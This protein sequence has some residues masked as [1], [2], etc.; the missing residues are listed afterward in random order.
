MKLVDL[1]LTKTQKEKLNE[2]AA[3]YDTDPTTLLT[4]LA[5]D[6]LD[7]HEYLEK[8]LNDAFGNKKNDIIIK[9]LKEMYHIWSLEQNAIDRICEKAESHLTEDIWKEIEVEFLNDLSELQERSFWEGAQA[10]SKWKGILDTF[11]TNI[12]LFDK[13]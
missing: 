12:E 11:P 1:D 4:I 5:E 8:W 2:L 9:T 10:M 6:L 3:M 13:Q 7:A